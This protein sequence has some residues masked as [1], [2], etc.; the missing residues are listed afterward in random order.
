MVC[1]QEE[2]SIEKDF[3]LLN[4]MTMLDMI[5]LDVTDLLYFY[6]RDLPI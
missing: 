2:E 3:G 6:F 5:A 4:S 1:Q